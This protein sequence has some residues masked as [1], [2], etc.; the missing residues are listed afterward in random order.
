MPLGNRTWRAASLSVLIFA[1]ACSGPIGVPHPPKPTEAAR[2]TAAAPAPATSE[3]AAKNAAALPKQ[4][5]APEAKQSASRPQ[6]SAAER[7]PDRLLNL[8]VSGLAGILGD[9]TFKRRDRS[10]RVWQYRDEGCI[11]DLFLY[12]KPTEYKVTHYEFRSASDAK[13]SGQGC[14]ERLLVRTRAAK[15]G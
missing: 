4:D 14:F 13:I 5:P 10:V 9:P 2:A 11:L 7:D 8:D 1:A 12:P 15:Q 6:F 3:P